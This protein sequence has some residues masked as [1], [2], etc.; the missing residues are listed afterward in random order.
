[1]NRRP[2]I[3]RMTVMVLA[4][5]TISAC[6][7]A[8]PVV[9]Q[10]PVKPAPLKT[11]AAPPTHPLPR[12]ETGM[13]TA[14]IRRISVDRHGRFVVT[15]SD[16]KT[17]RVWDAETGKLLQVLRPPQAEGSEGKIYAVAISPDG[18]TVAVGGWTGYE[19]DRRISIYLFSRSDGQ[20][21]RRLEALP[22]VVS[23][24]CFSPDGR[25]LAAALWGSKG[26]RVFDTQY[27]HQIS[28][29]KDYGD[30]SY[31][32]DFDPAGRLITT[33]YDG[34]VR[35]YNNR[36]QIVAKKAV[37]GGKK[38]YT[39]RFSPDGSRVAVV[40]EDSTAVD[41]LSDK[42]LK[43]QFAADTEGIDNGN[44]YSVAWSRDGRILYTAGYYSYQSGWRPILA[45]P[46]KGRGAPQR[47]KAATDTILDLQAFD[48][49]RIAFGACDPAV[50]VFNA[51]GSKRFIL[52]GET[53]D[54]R[55]SWKKLCLSIDGSA[56]A[57]GYK[58]LSEAGAWSWQ[59][60]RFDIAN[61][62]LSIDAPD[63]NDLREPKTGK[64]S[65]ANWKATKNPRVHGQALQLSPH[66][67]SISLAFAPSGQGFVIGCDWYVRFYNDAVTPPRWQVPVPVAWAVN[68]TA[69][70]RYV[71]AALGD[72]TLR[73]YTVDKG[74]EVLALFVHPDGKRWI[75]WTPQGFFDASP[76]GSEI[77]GY[78]LNQG[79]DKAGEFVAAE[80]LTEQFYRHDLIAGLFSPGGEVA[81]KAAADRIGDVR[82][83]LK[84]GLPP[85]LELLSPVKS[86]STGE[87]VFQ[88]RIIDQGG[89]V[90]RF[91][92][93]ID[94][95][96]IQGRPADIPGAGPGTVG[97]RFSLAPGRRE[98]S[99][100]ATNTNGVASTPVTAV[101]DVE[102]PTTRPALFVFA[103]G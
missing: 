52:R 51:D 43:W 63:I 62:Q 96:E 15:G 35:L 18:T 6:V 60:A 56:V 71:V 100:I 64:E 54:F 45:R 72:G 78:H 5:L 67:R 50:G 81:L 70:G 12:I 74:R 66:E 7:T 55:E 84:G 39:A 4:C 47:W 33:C 99:L 30:N 95:K 46:E 69:D 17:A 61:G 38:P 8:P 34:N 89:G 94:G 27:W 40:F 44:M 87:F 102:A 59:T 86:N 10:N 31:S 28:A 58:T 91:I 57:F 68:I 80:Q 3:F 36:F 37:P 42:D 92:Y 93:R 83:V 76:G 48:D 29:D 77:F 98:I 19:W 32:V 26:V 73:W 24:L 85:K 75:A 20:L 41:V 53:L 1:M 9:V 79:A 88:A 22:E 103:A 11:G 90:S 23:D 49:G 82:Q 65:T 13:H 21:L 97:R 16:D 101:V 25:H 2:S 14:T